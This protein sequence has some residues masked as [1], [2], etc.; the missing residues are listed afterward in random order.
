MYLVGFKPTISAFERA[1]TVHVLNSSAIVIGYFT[2]IY[3]LFNDVISIS[4]YTVS[5]DLVD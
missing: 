3:D 2:T 4:A 5:N 1:K